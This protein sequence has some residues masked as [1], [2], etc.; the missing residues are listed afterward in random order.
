MNPP[1]PIA[2]GRQVAPCC[3]AGVGVGVDVLGVVDTAP[4][5]GTK[6]VPLDPEPPH[7]DTS[8]DRVMITVQGHRLTLFIKNGAR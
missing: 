6:T 1:A 7:P 5:D 3:V 8:S 4:P 2:S